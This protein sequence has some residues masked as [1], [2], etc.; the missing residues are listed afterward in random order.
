[1][2]RFE[3]KGKRSGAYHSGSYDSPPYMLLNYQR[4]NL[5]DVFTLAHEAGHAMHSYY[6]NKHQPYQDHSY[7][8]FVAEVASTFNEQLLMGELRKRYSD[9]PEVMTYLINHQI[10]DIKGTFFRQVM[11]AEFEL[12]LHSRAEANKPTTLD[13]MRSIYR[14]L[15]EKYFGPAVSF[16][17]VDEL[18]CLRIPHFYSAF[19]VYKYAT[20]LAAAMSLSDQVVSQGAAA[21]QRYLQFLKSGASKRPLELLRDAGVDLTEPRSMQVLTGK[22]S[23]LVSEL[24]SKLGK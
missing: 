17:A 8:I 1:A 13:A 15:L 3:N 19:Y 24:E 18:E 10:D 22:F 2:D 14:R 4:E 11:F 21:Q 20:G 16:S 6:S 5:S 9:Q 7:T 23:E 12:E